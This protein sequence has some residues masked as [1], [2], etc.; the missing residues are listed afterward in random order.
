MSKKDLN[1]ELSFKIYNSYCLKEF[2]RKE[3]DIMSNDDL[4]RIG[5][6]IFENLLYFL[7]QI[8]EPGYIFPYPTLSIEEQIRHLKNILIQV[9]REQKMMKDIDFL[10]KNECSLREKDLMILYEK[11]NIWIYIYNNYEEK[12]IIPNSFY[13]KPKKVFFLYQKNKDEFFIMFPKKIELSIIF[14]KPEEWNHFKS[15]LSVSPKIVHLYQK[16][17]KDYCFEPPSSSHWNFISTASGKNSILE[18]IL[19]FFYSMRIKPL[20]LPNSSF[21]WYNQVQSLREI[22]SH[23]YRLSNIPF[24]QNEIEHGYLQYEDILTI[25]KRNQIW[26]FTFSEN[27]FSPTHKGIWDI[28]FYEFH[29]RG[30]IFLYKK[31]ENEYFLL[32]PKKEN[33]EGV[34]KKPV[35]FYETLKNSFEEENESSDENESLLLMDTDNP[36][37]GKKEVWNLSQHIKQFLKKNIFRHSE[38]K[39]S[40]FPSFLKQ[41]NSIENN[42]PA[43]LESDRESYLHALL[44]NNYR[45]KLR[46]IID[47][48]HKK[49]KDTWIFILY[50]DKDIDFFWFSRMTFPTNIIVLFKRKNIN[51]ESNQWSKKEFYFIEFEN[52]PTEFQPYF[53]EEKIISS[54]SSPK[55]TSSKSTSSKSTSSKLSPKSTSSKLSPKLTSSKL[56]PKSTSSKLSPKL[57]SSKSSERKEK[58]EYKEKLVKDLISLCR[59]RG[60]PLSSYKKEYIIERL[61]EFDKNPNMKLKKKK[62]NIEKKIEKLK[63]KSR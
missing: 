16:V 20:D 19:Y 51:I 33:H 30:I 57:T 29:P 15:F 42:L 26:A 9:Y 61:E 43:N 56:S 58:K 63:K 46:K 28:P 40:T 5:C 24:F 32:S 31:N 23:H 52:I 60:I 27:N 36:Y 59:E 22:I 6:S 13:E 55:S 45:T 18:C 49:H 11:L 3:W 47:T 35:S 17:V 14:R 38:K 10:E 37:T 4:E 2:Q 48:F 25:F 21:S 39:K 62:S 7:H 12:W 41:L 1:I 44:S 8:E 50:P 34:I 53:Q 54:K